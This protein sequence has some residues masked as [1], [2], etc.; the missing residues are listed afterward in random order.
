MKSSVAL[1]GY[2]RLKVAV[3]YAVDVMIEV[4]FEGFE[5]RI[6]GIEGPVGARL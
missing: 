3:L 5:G 1:E 6:S 4:L 2:S